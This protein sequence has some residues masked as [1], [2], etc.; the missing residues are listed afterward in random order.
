MSSISVARLGG[1]RRLDGLGSLRFTLGCWRP[2][3]GVRRCLRLSLVGGFIAVFA[4]GCRLPR[5]SAPRLRRALL[6]F[7]TIGFRAFTCLS[8][9]LFGGHRTVFAIERG[10]LLYALGSS[11]GD[12]R[13]LDRNVVFPAVASPATALAAPP[14][15]ALLL[16][17][18]FGSPAFR[19]PAVRLALA[20]LLPLLGG[21]RPAALAAAPSAP[22]TTGIVLIAVF[23]ALLS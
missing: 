11:T 21:G 20:S 4:C 7:R 3:Q 16:V 14:T 23:L 17:A 5:A 6:R 18:L 12:I 1:N 10:L 15:R 19:S 9:L 22:A 13:C 2:C 8:F